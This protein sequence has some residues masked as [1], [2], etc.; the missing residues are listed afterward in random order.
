MVARGDGNRLLR[1]ARMLGRVEHDDG[2]APSVSLVEHEKSSIA[3]HLASRRNEMLLDGVSERVRFFGM[4]RVRNDRGSE[5][6]HRNHDARC[7]GV[8]APTN[9]GWG[10]FIFV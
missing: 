9:A 5:G 8:T 7:T 6:G 3:L 4:N 2:E 10:V 1:G